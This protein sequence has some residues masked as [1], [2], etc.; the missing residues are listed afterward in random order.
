MDNS[1]SIRIGDLFTIKRGLATGDNSFFILTEQQVASYGISRKFLKP[2]L[3][4]PRYLREDEIQADK[5]GLPKLE[6]RLFLIDCS[7]GEHELREADPGL[8]RYLESG[9]NTVARRYLCSSRNPWYSQEKR[10]PAPFLCTYM[11]RADGNG[12][13]PFRFILNH[14]TATAA[15]VYLLMYPKAAVRH[16]I[17]QPATAQRIFSLLKQIP[18]PQLTGEGRVY[19]G[20]LHKLEPRELANVPADEIAAAL[21]NRPVTGVQMALVHD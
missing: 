3:P 16:A 12:T 10:P 2:V 9:R 13:R 17:A 15:N 20:G 11:G 19:G 14:S 6:Q 1:S 7:L 18:M 5:G 21:N 8:A 4:S